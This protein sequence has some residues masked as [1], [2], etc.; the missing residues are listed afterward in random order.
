MRSRGAT[1][2]L[3]VSERYVLLG[4]LLTILVALHWSGL[5]QRLN[6]LVWDVIHPAIHVQP[7]SDSVIVAVDDASLEEVGRWPWP[8]SVHARL[9]RALRES[10]ARTIVLD[11]LFSE[12]SSPE[13]DTALAQAISEQRDV[14]LP[15]HITPPDSATP[16][17]EWLPI[18]QFAD[19]AA[20]LG[21][22]HIQTDTDGI[23]RGLPLYQGVPE[24]WWPALALAAAQVSGL[25]VP[26]RPG[27]EEPG[28]TLMASAEDYRLIPFLGPPG[29]IPTVS[30]TDVLFKRLPEGYFRDKTVFIG[31][32][33]PGLGDVL[34]TPV[35]SEGSPMPGVEIQATVYEAIRH[36]R[37]VR[38]LSPG[39]TLAL[40][41]CWIL[42]TVLLFPRTPPAWNLPLTILLICGVLAT[43]VGLINSAHFWFPPANTLVTLLLA[44][45]LWSWRRL[46]R[47]NDYLGQEIRRLSHQPVFTHLRQPDAPGSW[48]QAVI[49]LLAPRHWR[50]LPADPS[51]PNASRTDARHI[52]VRLPDQPDHLLELTFSE[53]DEASLPARLRHLERVLSPVQGPASPHTGE[54]LED[55]ITAVRNAIT[56]M[57]QMRQ[58]IGDMIAGM[59]DGILVTDALGRVLYMN[60]KSARWLRDDVA[61]GASVAHALPE[62][63]GMTPHAWAALLQRT[64]I[65]GE[66]VERE[67]ILGDRAVLIQMSPMRLSALDLDGAVINFSDITHIH[68]AQQA[69]LETIHFIS[70]DLRAPLASQLAL[71]E[72]IASLVDASQRPQLEHLQQLTRRSLGLADEFLQLARVEAADEL[73]RFPCELG[74]IL[75]KSVDAL[76]PQ[77]R[78]RGIELRLIAD[79]EPLWLECSADL[80]ERA[81]VNLISNAVKFSPDQGAVEIRTLRRPDHV[82][83]EVCDQGPGIPEA[84]QARLFQRFQRTRQ[85]TTQRV[86]GA[87]LG[88]RFVAVVAERH[89]GRVEVESREGEG[90][91]FRLILPCI[92][93]RS[94]LELPDQ[95]A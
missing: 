25:R 44:Y 28:S 29:S 36:E 70:H 48:A 9:I 17:R 77:A 39:W 54:V 90:S 50:L 3:P 52:R 88:L 67:V 12:P 51:A 47:L 26:A 40:G 13:E 80:L 92:P 46:M 83:I 8:R 62:G 89:G 45:P 85:S 66:A 19:H 6:G 74:D 4:L 56:A 61:P 49:E 10:G 68:A 21:H 84:D 20:A 76:S 58:F 27:P 1:T 24:P 11:I 33:A 63:S 5:T 55:R 95:F 59:P 16:M 2:Q 34:P 43:S 60:T 78:Q 22:A 65:L 87:G 86:A 14:V 79:D 73:A 15:L 37:L 82:V 18:R 64:L 75:A 35:S 72:S 7:A 32:T 53:D 94:G 81:L 41:V 91:T 93:S 42:L 57:Q 30:A 71:L 31:A 23:A 38:P 69:R